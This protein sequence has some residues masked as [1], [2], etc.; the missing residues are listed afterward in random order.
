MTKLPQLSNNISI[1]PTNDEFRLIQRMI[2]PMVQS[3]F[4]PNTIKTPA[5]ALTI[6]LKGRELGIPPMQAFA[7]IN[8]IQGKPAISAELMLALIYKNYPDAVISFETN[9]NEACV[10]KAARPGQK[11]DSFSFTIQ[12]AE[13]AGL[14][15]GHSWKKYPASLLRA[16][17]IS[18]MARAKFPDALMGASYTPEEMGGEIEEVEEESIAN[19]IVLEDKDFGASNVHQTHEAPEAKGEEIPPQSPDQEFGPISDAQK[20]RLWAIA[21][22][23]NKPR[24]EVK[25]IIA[26]FGFDSS[27]K[28]TWDKYEKICDRIQA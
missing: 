21:G 14:A 12:D 5:Q 25:E 19:P 1:L 8:I 11:S 16:R 4:L 6:A 15:S 24:D 17:C 2:T 27:S 28:I 23:K 22:S 26:E 10:I 20:K 7:H 13:Q 9:T 3:G 18:A